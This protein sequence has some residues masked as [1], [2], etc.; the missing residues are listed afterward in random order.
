M[1]ACR[2]EGVEVV[3]EEGVAADTNVSEGSGGQ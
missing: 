1:K 2:E 3:E